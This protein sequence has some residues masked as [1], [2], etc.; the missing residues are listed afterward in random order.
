MLVA[1][2]SAGPP[3]M[4][5]RPEKFRSEKIFYCD[6]ITQLTCCCILPGRKLPANPF[7]LPFAAILDIDSNTRPG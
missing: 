1:K 2:K 6:F 3:L 7:P 5:G 4:E